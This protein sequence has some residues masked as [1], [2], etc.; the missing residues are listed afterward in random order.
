MQGNMGDGISFCILGSSS[1]GNCA[2]L[3]TP[4]CRV[5][6]DVGFTPRRVNEMLAPLGLQ[7]GDVDAIF[8][9]HEHSD[10]ISG[11]SGL[12]RHPHIQVFANRETAR[13]TQTRLTFRPAWQFFETGSTFTFRDLE[14][15]S[16]SIP[17]DAADPVGYVFTVTGSAA[18]C[19]RLAWC[20]DLGY[21]PEL[22]RERI[23]GV[24]V[25]VLESNYDPALL[26]ESPR[27]WTL[28]QRI[29][30]RHGHLSNAAAHEVLRTTEGASWRK[31]FL[32]HLSRE[33][34]NVALVRETFA[35]LGQ[36][37]HRYHIEVVDPC[38]AGLPALSFA[39]I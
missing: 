14:V 34:N 4:G 21:V 17:H 38:T 35:S 16:F 30:S 29:K 26:D 28:K 27:S 11:L 24:D 5:L 6:I 31:V 3:S 20:L 12:A 8:I 19:R 32:A 9:T 7:L 37:G 39:E 22:V 10:H 23:R 15:S 33:C 13:A 2:L 18:P 36:N 1:A 25:L